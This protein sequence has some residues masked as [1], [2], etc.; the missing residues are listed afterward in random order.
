MTVEEIKEA[1]DMAET[2]PGA[3]ALNFNELPFKAL[4]AWA[5]MNP[6][7]DADATDNFDVESVKAMFEDWWSSRNLIKTW[8]IG[9]D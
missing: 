4:V 3:N 7:Q 5:A 1:A 2:W 8:R 6:M 9:R